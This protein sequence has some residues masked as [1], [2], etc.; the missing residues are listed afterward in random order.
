[1]PGG[2]ILYLC[3]RRPD[4]YTANSNP[5][6]CIP[7]TENVEVSRGPEATICAHHSHPQYRTLCR[8]WHHALCQYRTSRSTCASERSVKDRVPAHRANEGA[9][10]N[11][12]GP[13]SE[14][15]PPGTQQSP[16]A[17]AR[18]VPGPPRSKRPAFTVTITVMP[19]P[20]MTRSAC[21][22][23]ECVRSAPVL[24]QCIAQQA[25]P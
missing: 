24:G 9:G 15:S 13:H 18:S 10:L 14:H 12:P 3:Q 11:F 19:I 20:H 7:P 22:L 6:N 17:Y 1:M 23:V 5:R 21:I 25:I 4:K 8:G 2:S 16:S